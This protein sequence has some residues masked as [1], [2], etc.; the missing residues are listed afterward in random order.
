MF[1]GMTTGIL[2]GGTGGTEVVFGRESMVRIKIIEIKNRFNF[3]YI[4]SMNQA[5]QSIRNQC[6]H[7]ACTKGW[8]L[9]RE[10]AHLGLFYWKQEPWWKEMYAYIKSLDVTMYPVDQWDWI[11]QHDI[12]IDYFNER[13]ERHRPPHPLFHDYVLYRLAHERIQ[14][15]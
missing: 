7:H 11:D 12:G 4:L 13:M 3:Y 6:R 14:S 10:G 2:T 8:R 5:Y 9:Q 15:E 1:T